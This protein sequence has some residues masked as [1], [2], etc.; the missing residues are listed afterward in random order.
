MPSIAITMSAVDEPCTLMLYWPSTNG[1]TV[2][3]GQQQRARRRVA[4]RRRDRIEDVAIDDELRGV[5]ADVDRRA[6][7]V[8]VMVSS[9]VPTCISALTGAVNV[10]W[11]MM[12]S[13]RTVLKPVSVN[14]TL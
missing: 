10:P 3:A 5:V 11:M 1:V 14:A 6:C 7:P 9:S 13:R 2:G 12:P 4:N 8:T